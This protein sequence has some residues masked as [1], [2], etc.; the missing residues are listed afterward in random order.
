M[1]GL[2]EAFLCGAICALSLLSYSNAQTTGLVAHWSFD[3][4]DGNSARDLVRG[5]DDKIAGW[6]KHVDGIAGEALRFDGGTT[7][8]TRAAED[9]PKI[10]DSFTVETWVAVSTYPWNWVPIIDQSRGE[11]HYRGGLGY[12]VGIDAFGHFGLQVS[13]NGKFHS[14]LSKDPLALKRWTHVAATFEKDRG[15]KIYVNG[16]LAGELAAPGALTPASRQELLIGRVREATLPLEWIHPKFPVWYSFDGVMDE[17]QVYDRA[18]TGPELASEFAKVHLP[19]ADPLTWPKLPSGPPGPGRFGAYYADLKFDELWDAPRRVG[20]YANVIVRFDQSPIRLV[21]WQGTDYIPAWVTENGKWYTDEFMETGG[22]PGCPLGED[23][24]PMSDKQNRYSHVRIL[25][26]TDA[27]A[28]VHWRYGLCE[29]EQYVC[30]NPDP[31]TGWTDWADEYYTVYPDGIAVRKGTVWS[32]NLKR[33]REFQETIVINAPGTRPE[34]N[35]NTDALTFSNMKGETRVVS[36]S[37]QPK[38][39]TR[40][41]DNIQEVN[42]K[43]KW[44]PFQIVIP[45]GTARPYVGEK[46]Y[47][48]FEW[49]NHWPVQQV[50]SSGISA[51]APD[52]TS[53]TSLSH[54]EGK[55]Y[56]QTDETI[57]KVMM[58]GLTTMSVVEL[59]PLAK[60]W[61][62]PPTIELN[63]QGFRSEGYDLTQRAFVFSRGDAAATLKFHFQAS[64]DSPLFHPALMIK[65]WRDAQPHLKVDGRAVSWGADYRFGHVYTLEGDNLV[66]WMNIQATKPVSIEIGSGKASGRK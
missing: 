44:K 61:L 25:E 49:W 50:K 11:E 36:W 10:T 35:I 20:P 51:T 39:G 53:S 19:A 38:K 30:A 42:L 32:S 60:S 37:D 31:Q 9:A 16:E 28:M 26:S 2:R 65:N 57:T 23:C 55:I 13:V 45:P 5:S 54:F 4:K 66:V 52:K 34:D 56:A 59:V 7:S 15:L 47:S 33:G 24:E 58:H 63:G 27:R 18:L 46:T 43:S 21:F 41:D 8:I 6:F 64:S 22:S 48:M 17:L 12:S 14:L 3:E 1:K 62:S 29:V 40:W